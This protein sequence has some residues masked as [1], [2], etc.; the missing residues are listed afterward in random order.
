MIKINGLFLDYDGTIS[1]QEVARQQSRVTPHLEA[2][3]N[4]IR[5][6]IPIGIITAKDLPFIT[7]R[8]IFAYAWGAIAGLEMKVGS[9]LFIARGLE[10]YLPDLIMALIFAKQNFGYGGIVEEKCDYRGLP[11]A[12]CVDWRQIKDKKEARDM[13][14][15]ILTH[16]KNLPLNVIEYRGKPYF[17]VYACPID[18]GQAL[19]NM[20]EKL[21]VSN[22]ILYMGDSTTDNPAFRAADVS[23]GVTAGKQKPKLDCKYW[24]EFDKVA[25]FLSY[26]MRNQFKFSPELPGIKPV[27]N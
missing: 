20:K 1:P 11:L 26:L 9:E 27:D 7:P 24:I 18:K 21:G 4:I 15:P 25:C 13:Y 17:D 22:G 14:L 19:R 8:T 6:S 12:F 2:L 10:E 23:I 3:L 16:C 5:R